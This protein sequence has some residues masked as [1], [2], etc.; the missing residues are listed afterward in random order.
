MRSDGTLSTVKPSQL[1]AARITVVRGCV[2][3]VFIVLPVFLLCYLCFSCTCTNVLF[4]L[5]IK[6]VSAR[7]HARVH[8]CIMPS[9][10]ERSCV[11][12][13][14]YNTQSLLH[15]SNFVVAAASKEE[16]C[17]KPISLFV[18]IVKLPIKSHKRQ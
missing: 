14:L 5:M 13:P 12:T 10:S 17:F 3:G 16:K 6:V 15:N 11:P 2:T 4:A 9:S 8:T 1:C 18:Y 7:R